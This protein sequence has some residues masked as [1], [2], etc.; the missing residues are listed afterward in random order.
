M[1]IDHIEIKNFKN[2]ASLQADF[3][4]G[5][6]LFVGANGSGKTSILEALCV[7]VGA[8]FGSQEQKMQRVI[9]F[10]EIKITEGQREP[11]ATISAKSE[12]ANEWSRTINKDTKNN[13]SKA[14]K[15]LSNYGLSFFQNFNNSEDYTIAPLIGYYS[16]QRLFKDAKQSK[17]QQYDQANGRRNGYIQCLEDRAIKP[18]LTE[19]LGKAVT[20]R[21]TLQIKEIDLVDNVLDNVEKAIKFT[22][23]KF[24]GLPEDF[25]LKIYQ[26]PHFGFE[27]FLEYDQEHSLPLSYYSDGFRNLL[28]L[29]IDLVW[30]ASQLNPWLSFDALKEQTT[31]V[32]MIDEVDLHLHPRWQG[33]AIPMLQDLFPNVQFFITTHSPIVV[34]NFSSG[35]L[36]TISD[37]QIIPCNEKYFGKEVNSILRNILQAND[38]HIETK[39]KL[40]RLFILIDEDKPE[41]FRPILEGLIEVLG[42]SEPDIQR[43]LSLIAWNEYKRQENAIH[44]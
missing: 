34:A 28:F 2:F 38:R 11:S 44:S 21:A 8:F 18:L 14:I 15:P 30:R 3:K 19:W 25:P 6:N 4:P 43:A 20:L 5:V 39:E 23:I 26:D 12:I 40:D 16:S 13:D 33:L 1:Q 24:E 37:N 9:E 27:L 31:G 35:A 17:R 29:V 41:E 22:L 7:A 36:Y 32:V 42:K 10:E